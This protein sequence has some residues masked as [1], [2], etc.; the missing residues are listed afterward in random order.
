MRQ[1]GESAQLAVAA[2]GKGGARRVVRIAKE[3]IV[4]ASISDMCTFVYMYFWAT[5]DFTQRIGGFR[6]TRPT[7]RFQ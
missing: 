7:L 5:I 2:V 4:G 1:P 6:G 3:R